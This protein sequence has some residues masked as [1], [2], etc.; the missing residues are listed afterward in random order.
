MALSAS[1]T[2]TRYCTGE[3]EESNIRAGWSDCVG[4]GASFET[5]SRARLTRLY[6]ETVSEKVK[7]ADFR[8]R[9]RPMFAAFHIPVHLVVIAHSG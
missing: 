8:G 6:P 4:E 2:M 3:G 5:P 9:S 7:C 1:I